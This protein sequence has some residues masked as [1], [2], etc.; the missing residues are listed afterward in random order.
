MSPTTDKF[1]RPLKIGDMGQGERTAQ[2]SAE[3]A[4]R[5]V[6][7]RRLGLVS[8]DRLTAQARI[9]RLGGG[10]L[11]RAR[12]NLI[13]DVVQCCVVT[14][15]P[16]AA[17]IVDDFELDFDPRVEAPVEAQKNGATGGCEVLVG[18]D[19]EEKPEPMHDGSIDLGEVVAVHLALV[20]DPYPRTPGVEF[21][22]YDGGEGARETP[23]TA[24]AGIQGK[25]KR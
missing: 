22:G 15:Q 14:L 19:A 20:L 17:R 11:V 4:E 5:E 24:L 21:S 8:L 18:L 23:F 12:V 9:Q 2:I 13:A 6:L 1:S 16:V 7:S 3:A 25:R 10:P